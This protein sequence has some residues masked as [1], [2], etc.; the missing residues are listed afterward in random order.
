[1]DCAESLALLSEYRDGSLERGRRAE[2]GSH[3]S[4]CSPCEGIYQE[5]DVIA[6]AANTLRVEPGIGFPDEDS[7]WQRLDL[8]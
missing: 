8:K 2:V 5:L 3:L 7:L 1:M 4:R 6:V